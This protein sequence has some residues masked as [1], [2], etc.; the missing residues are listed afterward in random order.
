MQV[1][2]I[3]TYKDFR[4]VV[5]KKKTD[6]LDSYLKRKCSYYRRANLVTLSTWTTRLVTRSTCLTTRSTRTSRL[7]TRSTRLSTGSTCLSIPLLIHSSRLSIRSICLYT[8]STHST[9]CLSF[10]NWSF[11]L[12]VFNDLTSAL[13]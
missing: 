2:V 12:L 4:K 3:I 6:I 11:V 10:Y 5:F 8:R 1:N 7:P 13:G 9:I